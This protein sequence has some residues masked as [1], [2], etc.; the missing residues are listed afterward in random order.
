MTTDSMSTKTRVLNNSLLGAWHQVANPLLVE[1]SARSDLQ[2]VSMDVQHGSFDF[3]S[4][5]QALARLSGS[6]C[7]VAVRICEA[8]YSFAARVVD[9]GVNAIVAPLI[10]TADDVREFVSNIKYPPLGNRSWG[11]ADAMKYGGFSDANAYLK[12][13]NDNV[14]AIAMI[15]T[16]DAYKNLD[17]ILSVDGL[18]GVLVGPSDLSIAL[19]NGE[20]LNPFGERSIPVIEKVA[21]AAKKRGKISAIFTTKTEHTKVAQ[22]L[23]YNIITISTDRGLFEAGINK[24]LS[25]LD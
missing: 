13:A 9:A 24:L 10:N 11:P 14:L 4:I 7:I 1:F 22:S 6:D 3:T 18:D 12:E 16:R 19:S 5:Q 8:D 25:A 15:E 17:E 23:G 21:E 20:E 2:F